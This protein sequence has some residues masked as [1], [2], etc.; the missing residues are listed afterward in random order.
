M[1]LKSISS[2]NSKVSI[3]RKSKLSKSHFWSNDPREI[4]QLDLNRLR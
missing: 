4:K 1:S 3:K 2:W